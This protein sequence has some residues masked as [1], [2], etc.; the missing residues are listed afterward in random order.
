MK[1]DKGCKLDSKRRWS[2]RALRA[3]APLLP[4]K[5]CIFKELDHDVTVS[6]AAPLSYI[7]SA[8]RY[9]AHVAPSI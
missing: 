1:C 9:V 6:Q 4:R 5:S 2:V 8:Q 7:V 3:R